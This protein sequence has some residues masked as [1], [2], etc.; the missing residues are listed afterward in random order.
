MC[1]NSEGNRIAAKVVFGE[2]D[3][4]DEKRAA[5]ILDSIKPKNWDE[6][7]ADHKEVE[8]KEFR[9]F[10][11]YLN[12]PVYKENLKIESNGK[13]ICCSIFE[14][15]I[16]DKDIYKKIITSNTEKTL[17]SRVKKLKTADQVRTRMQQFKRLAKNSVK[18]LKALRDRNVYHMDIK[19]SNILSNTVASRKNKEVSKVI[20]QL[21]DFGSAVTKDFLGTNKENIEILRKILSKTT[22]EYL[23]PDLKN[24]GNMKDEEILNK[25]DE[26]KKADLWSLGAS[27]L[28]VYIS[29]FWPGVV[30]S[31]EL[32]AE[33]NTVDSK[34]LFTFFNEHGGSGKRT[35]SSIINEEILF[36]DGILKPLLRTEAKERPE[37]DKILVAKFFAKST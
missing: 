2:E 37:L 4:E 18:A 16:A 19:P 3:A 35:Q 25:I 17:P 8:N 15:P 36:F 20:Y 9:R 6:K 24:A 29:M 7:I 27:L 30:F 28:E 22:G 14:A 26:I 1:K 23:P 31:S 21:S 10:Y 32:C 34:K 11:K 5:E 13:Q 33:V 12:I